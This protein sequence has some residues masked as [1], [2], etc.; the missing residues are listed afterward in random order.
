MKAFYDWFILFLLSFFIGIFSLS[1]EKINRVNKDHK[2]LMIR[3]NL[4]HYELDSL[5]G[6]TKFVYDTLSNKE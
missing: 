6:K 3:H 4:A 1:I 2:R 5:T